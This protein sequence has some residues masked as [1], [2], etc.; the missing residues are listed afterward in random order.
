MSDPGPTSRDDTLVLRIVHLAM[1]G[2]VLV[3]AGVVYFLLKG[4]VDPVAADRASAFRWVWLA[5]ALALVFA[6]GIVRGRLPRGAAP[7]RVRTTAILV[8]ALA[9]ATAV[10]GIT[11][12]LVTGDWMPLA[13][14]LLVALFLFVHH[15][16][17]TF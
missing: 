10:L 7:E 13:G 15:R 12:A 14:G 3:F 11:F 1:M 2:G 5:A 16:P 9:E 6:A 4:G 8:W 17:S